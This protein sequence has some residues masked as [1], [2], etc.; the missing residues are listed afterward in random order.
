MTTKHDETLTNGPAAAALL[1]GGIGALSYGIF[2]I[3][4]EG[5][6]AI[7]HMLNWYNP[8]GNLSGKSGMMI[9]V[10]LVSWAI[11]NN[12]WQDQ[13]VDFQKIS[14]IALTLLVVGVFLTIPPVFDFFIHLF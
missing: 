5:V 7:G 8:S 13:D 11:L 6:E 2:I 9:I 14:T 10:W 12:K 1:A 3:L 4:S